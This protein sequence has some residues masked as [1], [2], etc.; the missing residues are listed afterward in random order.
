MR[1][2]NHK[3]KIITLFQTRPLNLFGIML[4]ILKSA[5]C[6]SEGEFF[7]GTNNGKKGF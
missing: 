2:E 5:T 6:L 3:S 4:Y 7:T 1:T